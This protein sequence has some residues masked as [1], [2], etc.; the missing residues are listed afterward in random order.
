MDSFILLL[1]YIGVGV[2][3]VE[4]YKPIT[5]VSC[6]ILGHLVGVEIC[7]TCK[8]VVEVRQPWYNFAVRCR[9]DEAI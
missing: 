2:V 9:G 8:Q 3:K 7:K 4:N 5:A 6:P 1:G